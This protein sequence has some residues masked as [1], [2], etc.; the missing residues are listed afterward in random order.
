MSW[1]A[2][3]KASSPRILFGVP[4]LR[5]RRLWQLV[6]VPA[7][8]A[9]R[10][11]FKHIQFARNESMQVA[12]GRQP[13]LPIQRLLDS[14]PELSDTLTATP[15]QEGD[16]WQMPEILPEDS[17]YVRTHLESSKACVSPVIP[18]LE[19]DQVSFPHNNDN[20]GPLFKE[21]R[22]APEVLPTVLRLAVPV[23]TLFFEY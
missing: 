11:Q 5:R 19:N 20:I 8:R 23:V 4:H 14:T 10:N 2:P 3:L 9:I 16:V 15:E 13:T 22:Q 21:I 18:I 7:I 1:N 12:T 17:R 6:R